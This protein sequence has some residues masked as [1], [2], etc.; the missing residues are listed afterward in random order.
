MVNINIEKVPNEDQF[1]IS[2]F[3]EGKMEY[4]SSNVERR[5]LITSVVLEAVHRVLKYIDYPNTF[6][7]DKPTNK[8]IYMLEKRNGK[9]IIEIEKPKE[10]L[11]RK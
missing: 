5:E 9:K 4:F 11:E 2:I 1:R 7:E 10:I 3:H 6:K 8:G